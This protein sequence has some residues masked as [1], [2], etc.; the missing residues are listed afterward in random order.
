M[1]PEI[2]LILDQLGPYPACVR[3]ARYDILGYNATY[4]RLMGPLSDV[5]FEDRNALWLP[6][7]HT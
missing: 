3:N 7:R 4:E 1:P 6:L 5:P 2:Q